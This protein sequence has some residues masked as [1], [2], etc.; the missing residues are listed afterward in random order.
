MTNQSTQALVTKQ[1]VLFS[2]IVEC[3]RRDCLI[4]PDALQELSQLR[5]M[6][7]AG[8]GLLGIFHAYEAK[9]S[10]VARRLV[11]AGVGGSPML[12]NRATFVAPHTA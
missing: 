3:E 10:G 6:D 12:M 8:G 1:G 2:V 9:I 5:S 11:G 7:E 4:T